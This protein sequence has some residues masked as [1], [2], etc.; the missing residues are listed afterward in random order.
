M[1]W[2]GYGLLL[3]K[4]DSTRVKK[5]PFCFQNKKWKRNK[6]NQGTACFPL[7]TLLSMPGHILLSPC[8]IP[9]GYSISIQA[10]R[11]EFPWISMN[12]FCESELFFTGRIQKHVYKKSQV[13]KIMMF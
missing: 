8:H 11:L 12:L 13:Y 10:E 2:K 5:Y 6:P 3:L 9:F 7:H 1:F 4:I